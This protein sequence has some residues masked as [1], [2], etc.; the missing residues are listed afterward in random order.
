MRQP[1]LFWKLKKISTTQ[2]GFA[3]DIER[4]SAILNIIFNH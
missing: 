2:I 4:G 3:H 1:L